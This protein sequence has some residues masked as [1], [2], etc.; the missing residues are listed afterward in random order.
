MDNSALEDAQVEVST[1][2]ISPLKH[3]AFLFSELYQIE[4]FE[5]NYWSVYFSFYYSTGKGL[6]D[7]QPKYLSLFFLEIEIKENYLFRKQKA[8]NLD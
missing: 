1:M 8:Y 4:L 5:L 6:G 3:H 2:K 7:V